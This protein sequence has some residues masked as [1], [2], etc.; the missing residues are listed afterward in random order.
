VPAVDVRAVP[1]AD[2]TTAAPPPPSFS[3][4]PPVGRWQ[5]TTPDGPSPTV[6][7][8]AAAAVT[9][10]ARI[11]GVVSLWDGAT[12]LLDEVFD[13]ATHGRVRA[14]PLDA[15]G[16]PRGE[17]RLLLRVS[18]PVEGVDAD[19]RADSV[20]ITFARRRGRMRSWFAL[21]LR[22]DARR[23]SPI[24]SLGPESPLIPDDASFPGALA[25]VIARNDGG[26]CVARLDPQTQEPALPD[27]GDS[28]TCQLGMSWRLDCVSPR[29][30]R[31][32]TRATTVACISLEF[33]AERGPARAERGDL[34]A[35][36]AWGADVALQAMRLDMHTEGFVEGLDVIDQTR[37]PAA[38]PGPR[39]VGGSEACARPTTVAVVNEHWIEAHL[40]G[41]REAPAHCNFSRTPINPPAGASD[42]GGALPGQGDA[43]VDGVE[44]RCAGPTLRIVPHARSGTARELPV[45]VAG[46]HLRLVD[47]VRA[48]MAPTALARDD[49]RAAA[50]T[51]QRLLVLRGERLERWACEGAGTLTPV[52]APSDADAGVFERTDATPPLRHEPVTQ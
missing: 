6:A 48:A 32:R 35:L 2:A 20:W 49:F 5:P 31:E 18:S 52:E 42:D 24:L 15:L 47:W 36:G 34:V 25:R 10:R 13:D 51:G 30:E 1:N 41:L 40:L 7:A 14:Q 28:H 29:H 17:A 50:W 45:G 12:L 37:G 3:P 38:P 9:G 44:L 43:W 8:D 16:S 33:Q 19:A 21:A 23:M 4:A 27:E 46:T 39:F 11:L 26:A 22:P